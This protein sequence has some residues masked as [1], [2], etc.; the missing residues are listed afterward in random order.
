MT[1]NVLVPLDGFTLP[2]DLP[3]RVRFI[4]LVEA[5]LRRLHAVG[6]FRPPRFFG[7]Y[8]LDQEPVAVTGSWTVTLDPEKPLT[9]LPSALDRVTC[10]QFAI[11]G[12]AD[13]PP[14]FM[15]IH[16]RHDGA[17]WLW[18]FAYGR[19]FVMATDP[20]FDDEEDEAGKPEE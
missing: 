4:D 10:G 13:S 18:R 14:D 6:R 5:H 11:T 12:A 8:F 17:C 15:L 7:Y 2:P 20:L 19:R 16:D 1:D 3:W 9:E